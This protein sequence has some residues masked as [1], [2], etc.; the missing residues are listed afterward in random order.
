FTNDDDVLLGDSVDLPCQNSL[1]VEWRRANSETLVHL[2]K[3]GKSQADE[4]H[5]DYHNR[6]YFLEKK[7]K[8]GNF[9]LR[10]KRLRAG[11]EGVYRCKVY[12]DQE[13]VHSDDTELKL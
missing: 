7:T 2:Y 11:D 8:D 3:D 13:C 4:Q 10:L 6:A 1:K 9:S 5:K 12:R